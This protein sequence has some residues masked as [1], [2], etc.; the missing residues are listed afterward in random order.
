MLIPEVMIS[1]R[2]PVTDCR[3]RIESALLATLHDRGF[4]LKDIVNS[5]PL[6]ISKDDPFVQRLTKVYQETTGNDR[7][8][9]VIDGG[10]YARKLKHA[11]GF[12]GGTG[13]R[14]DF[15][16]EGHGAVHQPDEARSIDGILEAIKIYVLS[17]ME[18]DQMIQEEQK[19]EAH[20]Q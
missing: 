6:Y 13:I 7:E 17:V 15:L 9:Y 10:T 3:E 4:E 11:V 8:P 18:I 20:R 2:Y 14:A 19:T 5:D 16:P 12:G 1:S